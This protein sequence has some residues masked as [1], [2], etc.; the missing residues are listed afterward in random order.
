MTKKIRIRSLLIGGMITILFIGLVLRL[1]YIQVV[2]ASELLQSAQEKWKNSR[3]LL[4]ERGTIYDRNGNILAKDATGY[5]VAVNPLLIHKNGTL[6]EVVNVLAPIL[7][8]DDAAGREKLLNK[9]SEKNADGKFYTQ[10]EIISEGWKV[11]ADIKEALLAHFGSEEKMNASGIVLIEVQKRYYPAGDLASHVL[12]YMRKDD[13]PVG[14]I[15]Y[16][17]HELLEG[18]PGSISYKRDRLGYE[19]PDADIVYEPA[20][21]GKALKLTIDQNIQTY[22][23]QSL[24][25]A[26]EKYEPKSMTAIAVDPQTLEILG[27]ANYP[28]YDPNTYWEYAESQA[29]FTNHAALSTYEPGSTFK[30][31]TLASAVEEGLFDPQEKFMSGKIIYD[32]WPRAIHDHDR[33]GWGEIT[34]LDGL[35]R[36]SNVAFIKLGYEKLGKE[37]LTQYIKDFGFGAMTGVDLPGEAKGIVQFRY[38]TDYAVAT[39]G[40]G[41]TVS[42]LQ[43]IAAVSAI[44]NGGKLLVPHLLKE[45]VDAETGEVEQTVEPTLV[46]QVIREETAREVADLLEQVVSDLQIGTGRRG[47]IEGYRIAGKTGT[48]Q[49]VENGKYADDKWV[50]SFIGFAPVENPKIALLVI[51]DQPKIK[52]YRDSGEVVGPVFREIMNKAL[53]YYGVAANAPEGGVVTISSGKAQVPD[54]IG[55]SLVGAKNM[56]ERHSMPYEIYGS[57]GTVL[58]QF[59]AAGTDVGPGQRLYVLTSPRDKIETPDLKG[60]SLRDA[61]EICSFLQIEC[62]MNG[63]GYVTAQRTEGQTLVLTLHSLREKLN[64]DT[65]GDAEEEADA[66]D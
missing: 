35:K 22:I 58:E 42:A 11:D 15:E 16:Y 40:Q 43:Q 20:V 21:N 46:R 54:L 33:V 45:V 18:T 19:L 37:K 24:Q 65:E 57:G 48:A 9:A 30:I 6:A 27:V 44:A 41:V 50:S 5:T 64:A 53:H 47:Y 60:K 56:A 26:Y 1:Y 29:N 8:M 63:E 36:S 31:V 4:P 59:P 39:F 62:K 17:Y 34:Y 7:G 23:E 61:L 55:T 49:V 25:T 3:Q 10:R 28:T 14:G 12:G 52:D 2:A 38:E 13:Q 32:G 66:D 51:A